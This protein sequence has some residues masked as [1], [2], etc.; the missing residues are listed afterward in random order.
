[1]I[2]RLDDGQK[3]NHQQLG[4]SHL[5]IVKSHFLIVYCFLKCC[6]LSVSYYCKLNIT[7][8]WTVGWTKTTFL[9]SYICWWFIYIFCSIF[10]TFV[11]ECIHWSV[12]HVY[13]L[14]GIIIFILFNVHYIHAQG[15]QMEIGIV[16]YLVH[17]Y[18][19]LF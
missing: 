18:C 3:M 14:C 7:G 19:S 1:M 13:L 4:S 6:Y 9:Q 2:N 10:S 11:S 5:L 12:L 17:I 15:Q 16:I 8:F